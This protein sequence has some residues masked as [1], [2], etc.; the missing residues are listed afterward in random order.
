MTNQPNS[1]LSPTMM[2]KPPSYWSYG[3]GAALHQN[4]VEGRL[5]DEGSLRNIDFFTAS[6]RK[7]AANSLNGRGAGS[8]ACCVEGHLDMSLIR[9]TLR[10]WRSVVFARISRRTA[11]KT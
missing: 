11:D 1:G 4:S 2:V 6:R 8:P 3:L 9:A 10:P 7:V 5:Q